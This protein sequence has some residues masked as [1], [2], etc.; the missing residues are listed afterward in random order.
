MAKVKKSK[1]AR[2]RST[3]WNVGQPLAFP[4]N[5]N[6]ER[7]AREAVDEALR[8]PFKTKGSKRKKK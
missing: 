7:A 3:E 5:G 1:S 2:N 4:N 6:F 8:G